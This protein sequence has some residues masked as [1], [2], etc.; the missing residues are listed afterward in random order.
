MGKL[1]RSLAKSTEEQQSQN[2]FRPAL[3]PDGQPLPDQEIQQPLD[4]SKLD[5]C[6]VLYDYPPASSPPPPGSEAIDLHV[7]KGDLVAVLSKTD[8][9]GQSSDWWRCR[10]RDGRMGYLP[11]VY[12]V[13]VQ[14]K[15]QGATR[16]I[17]EKGES[18]ASTMSGTRSAE[19]SRNNSM[20]DEGAK[21]PVPV[22]ATKG[23][24]VDGKG[25][26]VGPENFQNGG[27]YP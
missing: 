20:K 23:P 19:G 22:P 1:I 9:M 5:F 27:F 13:I 25:N 11:G 21:V 4:P 12:L 6:R 17:T 15:P 7:K 8:P 18:R 24:A 16:Q 2:G 10:A 14:R 26:A 3:G